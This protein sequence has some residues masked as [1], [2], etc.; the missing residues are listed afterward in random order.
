L[1][2]IRKRDI[3]LLSFSAMYATRFASGLKVSEIAVGE[4]AE[5]KVRGLAGAA[6][7][8]G[9]AV[10]EKFLDFF[11]GVFN[12]EETWR[13]PGAVCADVDGENI[14]AEATAEFFRDEFVRAGFH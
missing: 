14:A 6:V 3:D 10:F 5:R 11:A 1:Y 8:L 7:L 9:V 4:I 12:F 2:P 13:G